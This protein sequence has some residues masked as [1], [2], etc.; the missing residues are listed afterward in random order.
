MKMKK[1]RKIFVL[2]LV[3]LSL[4][5]VT[6]SPV[7]SAGFYGPFKFVTNDGKWDGQ[8]EVARNGE[9]VSAQ[10]LNQTN[11]DVLKV[12]LCSTN[13]NCTA[14]KNVT[15]SRAVLFTNMLKGKYY[16]DV[17]KVTNPSRQVQGKTTFNVRN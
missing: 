3:S 15:N 10:V 16:A 2:L 1:T 5:F 8:L 6:V 11:N 17:A 14:Y 4:L 13:G 12:R 7:F 9:T